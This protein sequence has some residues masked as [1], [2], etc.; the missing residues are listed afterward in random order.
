MCHHHPAGNAISIL[1]QACVFL[2]S[3]TFVSYLP[4]QLETAKV[5]ESNNVKI[6]FL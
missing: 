3:P 2:I 1:L 6:T 4:L 5:S